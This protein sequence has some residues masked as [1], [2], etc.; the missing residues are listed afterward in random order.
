M[1]EQ[2]GRRAKP[3]SA[4]AG[5]SYTTQRQMAGASRGGGGG[6]GTGVGN[7]GESL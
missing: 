3:S 5:P 6:G 7:E 4:L 1:A 2:V